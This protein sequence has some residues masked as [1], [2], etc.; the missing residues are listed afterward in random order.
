[1]KVYVDLIL[2][3]NIWLDFLILLSVSL[4]LKRYASI[5]KIFLASVIGSFS[6]FLLFFKISS[7]KLILYKLIISLF[8][9]LIAFKAKSFKYVL[10]NIIYFYLVS[11]ILAGF[12]YLIRDK[13]NINDFAHNFLFLIIVSPFILYFYYK[14][15]AKVNN[16]YK[17]LY[18]V[19]L[20]FKGKKYNFVAFLDTGNK[21]YDQYKKRPIVLIYTKEIEFD[22]KKGILV[23][24]KTASGDGLIKCMIADKIVI[25]N[26]TE[27]ENVVFGL[28]DN[29]FDLGE[30]NMILH[31][32]LI[33]G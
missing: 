9:N 20:S 8:I 29:K 18:N 5:K 1:M 13:L 24:Y 25:D 17:N 31:S 26:K 33:G 14:K 28:V 12:I 15:T 23:P 16:Y 19:S 21:L 27:R 7:I 4:I 11:T 6:T 32:D 30:V 22:Y 10:E 2:I 3:L